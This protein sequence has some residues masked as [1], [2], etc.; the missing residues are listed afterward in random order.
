[1]SLLTQIRAWCIWK[2]FEEACPAATT[3][4]ADF[5]IGFCIWLA[6]AAFHFLTLPLVP[7]EAREF[8]ELAHRYSTV[9]AFSIVS[10]LGVLRLL[11]VSWP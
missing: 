8:I 10:G 11:K 1:M 2:A 7:E 9:A 5:L 6:F 3:I 4:L